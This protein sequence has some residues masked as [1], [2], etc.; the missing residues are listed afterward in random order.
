MAVSCR[1]DAI[2][3]TY[4]NETKVFQIMVF[5]EAHVEPVGIVAEN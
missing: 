5:L 3:M 4:Y 2:I 1:S